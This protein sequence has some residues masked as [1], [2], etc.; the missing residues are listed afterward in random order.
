MKKEKHLS[1]GKLI[2]TVFF[3]LL[4]LSFL[5]AVV[6]A[7]RSI[8]EV[9][10]SPDYYTEEYYL[11]C[12]QHEDYAELTRITHQDQRLGEKNSE[13]IRQCQAAGLYYEATI[14]HQALTDAGMAEEAS[15]QE[16]LMKKYKEG[17]GDLASY[18]DAIRAKAESLPEYGDE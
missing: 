11:S 2:L 6:Q 15:R 16:T 8:R 10:Y 4:S 12:L 9:D 18:A 13:T 3:V 14:L 5:F 7:V 17:L 1:V